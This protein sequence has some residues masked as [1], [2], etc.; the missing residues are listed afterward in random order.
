[1]SAPVDTAALNAAILGMVEAEM[2]RQVTKW[3]V[4]LHPP[5]VWNAIL[6]EEVGEVSK[7]ILET[8]HQNRDDADQGEQYLRELVQVAA[9]AISAIRSFVLVND[10]QFVFKQKEQ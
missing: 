9:V 4:Q 7:A 8:W 1:M 6:G 3:G 2:D 5:L 10:P